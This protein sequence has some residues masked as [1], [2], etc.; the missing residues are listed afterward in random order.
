MVPT[1]FKGNHEPD[2]SFIEAAT[3]EI[4]PLLNSKTA[5]DTSSFSKPLKEFCYMENTLLIF[6]NKKFI[7]SR[8]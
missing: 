3:K 4:I 2:I 7:K 6:P 8:S 1:P 5:P